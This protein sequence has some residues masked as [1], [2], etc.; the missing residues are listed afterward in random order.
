VIGVLVPEAVCAPAYSRWRWPAVARVEGTFEKN[1]RVIMA[2]ARSGEAD[3]FCSPGTF[4]RPAYKVMAA[5]GKARSAARG[6]PTP[7]AIRTHS[8]G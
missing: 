3:G 2:V 4:Q 5:P 8:P 1:Q 6:V 7:G